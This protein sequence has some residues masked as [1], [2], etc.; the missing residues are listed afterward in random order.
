MWSVRAIR[1]DPAPH[2]GV[3][4]RMTPQPLSAVVDLLDRDLAAMAV[5]VETLPEPLLWESRPGVINPVGT[6]ALHVSGNL[7]HFVGA[8][9]GGD[10]YVRDR[11]AEFERR[12]ATRDQV[13]SELGQ[14]RDAVAAALARLDARRLEQPMPSP[15]PPFEGRSIAYFLIQLCTHLA[16]HLGQADY[17]ARMLRAEAEG[18]SAAASGRPAAP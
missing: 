15:P 2:C 16:W 13:L 11:V 5:L 4:E 10:G 8:V 12:D 1:V 18:E 7:R 6:L 3:P 9:L 14:A 17:L